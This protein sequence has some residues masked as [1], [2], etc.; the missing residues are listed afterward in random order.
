MSKGIQQQSIFV[1]K[2]EAKRM[3][4][5][6]P[7]ERICVTIINMDMHLSGDT[8]RMCKSAGYE[9]IDAANKVLYENHCVFGRMNLI[10]VIKERNL[11]HCIT[12]AQYSPLIGQN[13]NECS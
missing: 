2:E 9:L 13:K 5:A 11:L 8:E 4:D 6:S 12:F 3:I 10:D 7:A 1:S